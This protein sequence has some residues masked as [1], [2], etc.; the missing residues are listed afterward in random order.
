MASVADAEGRPSALLAATSVGLRSLLLLSSEPFH[1]RS[2][3]VRR[4]GFGEIVARLDD[5]R[6]SGASI[7]S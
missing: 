7:I 1:S 4:S 3:L 5:A 2:D 6:Q